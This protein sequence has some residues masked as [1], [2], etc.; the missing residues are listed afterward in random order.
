MFWFC[1]NCAMHYIHTLHCQCNRFTVAVCRNTVKCCYCTI[2]SVLITT[3]GGK[4]SCLPTVG[5]AQLRLAKCWGGPEHHTQPQ[6]LLT[7]WLLPC[8]VDTAIGWM[9]GN[10]KAFCVKVLYDCNPFTSYMYLMRFILVFHQRKNQQDLVERHS[11]GWG[12]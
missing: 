7:C 8:M 4:S 5:A 1:L 3:S 2:T 11:W 6:L 9:W 12:G 10:C